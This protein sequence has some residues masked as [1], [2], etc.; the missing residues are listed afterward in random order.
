[1]KIY[2]EDFHCVFIISSIIILTAKMIK[3]DPLNIILVLSAMIVLLISIAIYISKFNYIV[4]QL[5]STTITEETKLELQKWSSILF[6]A[7]AIQ[8]LIALLIILLM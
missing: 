6:F 1:M 8:P 5:N 3:I 2:K 4:E 7:M